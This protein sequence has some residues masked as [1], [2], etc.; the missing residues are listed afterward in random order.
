MFY[1]PKPKPDQ[2]VHYNRIV[3][4][5]GPSLKGPQAATLHVGNRAGI[6]SAHEKFHYKVS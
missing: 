5:T 6:T 2:T 4:K 3:C 1:E